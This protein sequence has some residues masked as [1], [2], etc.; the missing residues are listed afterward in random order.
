MFD[1][2]R[3]T[4][5]VCVTDRDAAKG[6]GDPPF[7][8]FRWDYLHNPCGLSEVTPPVVINVKE[9]KWMQETEL[10]GCLHIMS[11]VCYPYTILQ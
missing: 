6:N 9:P 2:G 5:Y 11:V 7:P 1:H 10:N 8:T 4:D 3:T